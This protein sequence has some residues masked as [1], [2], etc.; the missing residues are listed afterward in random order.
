MLQKL[1]SLV[2]VN[3]LNLVAVKTTASATADELHGVE[4]GHSELDH[5]NRHQDGGAAQPRDTMD[6]NGRGRGS[7]LLLLAGRGRRAAS[8]DDARVDQLEPVLDD[9][10]RRLGRTQMRKR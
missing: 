7:F 4:V 2:S 3:V 9:V 8:P 10:D 6:C 1:A 5:G